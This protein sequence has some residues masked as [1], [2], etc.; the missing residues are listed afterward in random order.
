MSEDEDAQG[1]VL[2]A[3]PTYTDPNGNLT[4]RVG[5]NCKEFVVDA[6]ALRRSSS[7]FSDRIILSKDAS[8]APG[9]PRILELPDVEPAA[10]EVLL[11]MVHARFISVPDKPDLKLLHSV[12]LLAD[13]YE[14]TNLLQPWAQGWAQGWAHMT[15]ET[16]AAKL[17]QQGAPN[18]E[19]LQRIT[20]LYYLRS[21]PEL[22]IC[23]LQVVVATAK[24]D[25]GRLVYTSSQPDGRQRQL[26]WKDGI[27]HNTAKLFLTS[28][29]CSAREDALQHLLD[30]LEEMILSCVQEAE[31]S[32]LSK[33][34][35]RQCLGIIHEHLFHAQLY[36]PH[37][38]R[39]IKISPVR[40]AA[41][42]SSILSDIS[43][44]LDKHCRC[45][46][47]ENLDGRLVSFPACVFPQE[48]I[49]SLSDFVADSLCKHVTKVFRQGFKV[50]ASKLDLGE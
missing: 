38:A 41:I 16:Y 20:C 3:P 23:F 30:T 1:V 9:A 18:I 29:A 13:R 49:T 5:E 36:P 33:H 27:P 28:H 43:S 46:K 45:C 22:V 4:L 2:P 48:N 19:D 44:N 21:L 50:V 39:D 8:L 47:V 6:S 14:M 26:L 11:N 10:M 31:E 37:K 42:I 12:V 7:V 24:S 32:Q 35:A 15:T 40:L 25:S 34:C 17:E